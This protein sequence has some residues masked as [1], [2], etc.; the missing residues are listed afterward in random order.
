MSLAKKLPSTSPVIIP[1]DV[2]EM[3]KLPDA[4]RELDSPAIEEYENEMRSFWLRVVDAIN[5]I[6]EKV[7]S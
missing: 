6:S 5:S 1:V 4:V 3:P 7:E 2:E